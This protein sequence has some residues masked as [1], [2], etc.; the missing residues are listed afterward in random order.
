MT[1][2]SFHSSAYYPIPL[3]HRHLHFL[4]AQFTLAQRR[5]LFEDQQLP[6]GCKKIRAVPL[7]SLKVHSISRLPSPHSSESLATAAPCLHSSEPTPNSHKSSPVLP[8]EDQLNHS[9][10]P[11]SGLPPRPAL[12]RRPPH[13]GLFPQIAAGAP[14]AASGGIWGD[15]LGWLWGGGLLYEALLGH[16]SLGLPRGGPHPA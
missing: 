8:I 15:P 11:G 7:P 16:P 14:V 2:F 9:G 4:P 10:G 13:A 1:G 12:Q 5:F 6:T 3:K